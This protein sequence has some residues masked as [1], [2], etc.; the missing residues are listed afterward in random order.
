MLVL[1]IVLFLAAVVCGLVM[2]I[3]ILQDRP[4]NKTAKTLHGTFAGLALIIMVVYILTSMSGW[5][6][7]LITSL[8]LLISAALGGL[9]MF[10]MDRKNKQFPKIIALI[11]PI[12]AIAG[13]IALIIYVLP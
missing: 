2:L 11:H 13:L 1:A 5:S 6:S 4:T 10:M 8:V 12:I 9:T 7:L 3:A